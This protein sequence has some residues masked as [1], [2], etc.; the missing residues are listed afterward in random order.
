MPLTIESGMVRES[1]RSS[2][3]TGGIVIFQVFRAFR[4]DISVRSALK[5]RHVKDSKTWTLVA[6]SRVVPES[7]TGPW[8]ISHMTSSESEILAVGQ[9]TKYSQPTHVA[10]CLRCL[11]SIVQADN[12]ESDSF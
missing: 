9:L 4:K 2:R 11:C 3:G 7:R 10:V 1:R 8:A 6:R 5:S 12:D